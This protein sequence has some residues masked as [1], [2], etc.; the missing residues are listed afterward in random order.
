VAVNSHAIEAELPLARVGCG[1]RIRAR[2]GVLA[3]RIAA[4]RGARAVV[5]PFGAVDGIAL[6][7]SVEADPR[8]LMF[9]PPTA[10]LGRAVDCTGAPLDGAGPVRARPIAGEGR[11]PAPRDRRPCETAFWTGVRAIDGPLTLAR[12]ARIGLF[13][14]PGSGKSTLLDAIVRSACADAVVVAL[15]GE[16]GREAERRLAAIDARTTLVCATSDRAP[17]E[18]VRAAEVAFEHAAAL[19]ARGLHVLLAVDSLARIASAARELA[20]GCGEAAG[21]GGYP[22]SV[23]GLLA[24]LL[25]R[26]GPAA[27]GSMTLVATVLSDGPDERDPVS[28]AARAALDGHL[29]L[30]AELAQA[31]RFPA[32]DLV[33]STSR[34]LADA[35][36]PDHVRAARVLRSAV[37]AL[38]GARDARSIGLDPAACDPFLAR[39][40]EAEAAIERFLRQNDAPSTAESTLTDLVRLAD[41]IDDGRL[42]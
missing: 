15:I 22:P 27:E 31:G 7:D 25:E 19:R 29:V 26:A 6:G 21:R 17:A 4:L 33:A 14:G 16:R 41:R 12:G 20:L 36:S 34:T 42:L 13:G 10:L 28:E 9:P 23:F 35:A 5:T 40:I 2:D 3:A 32:L 1:V 37:A 30:S 39:C 38:D 18:R 11:A 24:R 8:V